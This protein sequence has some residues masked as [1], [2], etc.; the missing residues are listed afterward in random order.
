MT[1]HYD[2]EMQTII[3]GMPTEKH[4]EI[5]KEVLFYLWIEDKLFTDEQDKEIE[6]MIQQRLR[7]E[8]KK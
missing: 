6:L 5:C 8:W 4:N 2:E 3:D 7:E 1:E